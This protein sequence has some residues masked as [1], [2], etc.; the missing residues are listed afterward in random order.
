[1]QATQV[2]RDEHQGILA[3]LA[4][5][6][7]AANRVRDGKPVPA[8]LFLDAVGF[9]RGFADGCHHQK[10][11]A[12]LFPRLV[13]R[14]VPNQGGPVG[15]MLAEHDQGRALVSGIKVAAEQYAAGDQTAI[16]ALVG[17]TLA[18]VRLLR[19][20][21]DKENNILFAL[22][23]RVLSEA[24]EVQLYTAFEQIE[25]T[26]TGP[27]EHERY[28]AMIRDYQTIAAGWDAVPA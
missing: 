7:T 6:E 10:E 14:G 19:A 28:H 26:R 27:G 23:D 15:V 9:F 8:N 3:M 25:L 1:M 24:D 2:L 5:V 11:E 12:E 22:A 4:I 20:H 17:N 13:E 21:I 16:P 18:Y